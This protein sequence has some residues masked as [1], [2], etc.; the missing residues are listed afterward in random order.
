MSNGEIFTAPFTTYVRVCVRERCC[1]TKGCWAWSVYS[2]CLHSAWRVCVCLCARGGPV[3]A[4]LHRSLGDGLLLVWLL[5]KTKSHVMSS[6]RETVQQS[7]VGKQVVSRVCGSKLLWEYSWKLYLCVC[8]L[9]RLFFPIEYI[10]FSK[11]IFF[12]CFFL[13]YKWCKMNIFNATGLPN[14]CCSF[15]PLFI[16]K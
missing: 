7:I 11:K 2:T 8:I 12:V 10:Q 5:L 3:P 4:R 15:A 13:I 16:H 14:E 1:M 9:M 6:R